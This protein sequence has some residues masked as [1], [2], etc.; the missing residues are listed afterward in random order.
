MTEPD[1]H[2]LE[3]SLSLLAGLAKQKVEYALIR[4]SRKH[5]GVTREAAS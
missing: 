5:L 3:P 2:L 1:V 4:R